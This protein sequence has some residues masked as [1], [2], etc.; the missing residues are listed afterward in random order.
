MSF[1]TYDIYDSLTSD[2]LE[3]VTNI[4][5]E[6]LSRQNNIQPEVFELQTNIIVEA[7]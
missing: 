5:L 3:T 6:A 1:K 2:E 7:I 4:F